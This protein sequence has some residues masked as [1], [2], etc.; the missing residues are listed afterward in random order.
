M[1][2]ISDEYDLHKQ[3][4]RACAAQSAEMMPKISSP[5]NSAAMKEAMKAKINARF[6]Q[7]K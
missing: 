5:E 4:D 7:G 3:I 6:N 2:T 1:I